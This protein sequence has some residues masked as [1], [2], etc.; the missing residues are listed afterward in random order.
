MKLR[1]ASY[2]MAALLLVF[3]AGV[4]G[5]AAEEYANTAAL[6]DMGVGART[7]GMGGAFIGLADDENAALYNP[8]GLAFFEGGGINTT[9]SNQFD[10]VT[11]NSA[12][13][14]L[15]SFG[16]AGTNLSSGLID[17]TNKYGE[18]IGGKASYSSTGLVAGFGVSGDMVGLESTL[19]NMSIGVQLRSFHSS[20]YET[21][22]SGFSL[23][24]S[25]LYKAP[26]GG[27]ASLQ[28]GIIVPS[29]I[30]AQP[31]S[32]GFPLGT[33]TYEDSSGDV[34][35]KERFPNNFGVGIGIK[36]GDG[37]DEGLNLALDWRAQ[38]GVRVGLEKPFPIG[39]VRLGLTGSGTI[40]TGAGIKLGALGAADLLDRTRLDGVYK[41]HSEL[42]N[43]Y[44]LSFSAKM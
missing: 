2:L 28:F 16:I 4:A 38:G 27:G 14:A 35:N 6:F 11:Y 19:R 15:R 20:L 18:S 13:G 8:A 32:S 3:S 9:T 10:T 5:A 24:V 1:Y 40:T 7:L 26:I 31:I 33:I 23:S 42:G 25:S 37:E 44:M 12:V 29:F 21:Q 36:T 22:G 34:V 30:V 17:V 39:A 41:W 43:S